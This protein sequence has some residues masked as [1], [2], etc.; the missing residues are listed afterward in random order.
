M[1]G[2]CPPKKRAELQGQI[3]DGRA[4]REHL[5]KANTRLVVSIAKKYMGRGVPFL[6]LIQEGNL[7]LMKAVEKFDYRRGF[8][9]S[10]YATWWIRQTITRAIAD[11]GR[12]I[13]VPV[14]MSDRIRRLYTRRRTSWS[15]AGPQ[16]DAGGDRRAR[17]TWS[18]ARC[19]WML[20]VSLAP[21]V[22]G[23]AGGRGGGQR[24]G[25][26]SSRTRTPPRPT[27]VRLRRT[28]C[29][30]RSRRCWPRSPRA[31]RASCACAS[32]CRTASRYTL[33]EVGQKFGADPRAHP[34]DRG[35]GAAPAAPPAP[36]RQLRDYPR[37]AGQPLRTSSEAAVKAASSRYAPSLSRRAEG[38][39]S[40]E[41]RGPGVRGGQ[42]STPQGHVFP[43]VTGK[44]DKVKG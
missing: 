37:I 23:D 4:A 13:R 28:C 29:A 6:D 27:R 38:G 2:N 42:H 21:A 15:R 11:Q 40:W 35:Q 33:E 1:N 10:T 24:A 43:F 36:G 34:P 41:A 30:R 25:R 31:R 8:R 12:T 44:R 17:W 16:A 20:R 19:E 7:G 32:A 22:A 5:I 14:H 26:R 9:F 3:Q 39:P 18:R